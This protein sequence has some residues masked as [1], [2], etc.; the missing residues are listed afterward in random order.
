MGLERTG[1]DRTAEDGLGR[2]KDR[3]GME[4]TERER[5]E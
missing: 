3:I 4:R 5:L 1:R 2:A